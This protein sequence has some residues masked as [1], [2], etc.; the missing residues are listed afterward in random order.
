MLFSA[1]F[2]KILMLPLQNQSKKIY[3]FQF[4][5]NLSVLLHHKN[6]PSKVFEKY[7]SQCI[8]IY[9]MVISETDEVIQ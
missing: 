5:S 1:P 4:S 7:E 8:K 2:Y 3:P 6:I 9:K